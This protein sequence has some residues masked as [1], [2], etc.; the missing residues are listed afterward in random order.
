M[1]KTFE[2]LQILQELNKAWMEVGPQIKNYMESS[3]EI[4]LLQVR[5]TSCYLATRRDECV[6][7]HLDPKIL[8]FLHI[9]VLC[10]CVTGFVEAAR[11]GSIGQP[12][13]GEH[14]LDSL[15]DRTFPVHT[16][17]RCSKETWSTVYL[18]GHL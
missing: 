14:V 7:I 3:V 5:L 2:D 4:Q 6:M 11:G 13:S 16:L 12:T 15:T 17:T 10:V 18:A 9:L 8:F 1:N